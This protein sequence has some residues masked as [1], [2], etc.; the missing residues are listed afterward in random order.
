MGARR[1]G[2]RGLVSATWL[3]ICELLLTWYT[4]F[5]CTTWGRDNDE[6]VLRDTDTGLDQAFIG[7]GGG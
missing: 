5:I 4:G 7:V 2:Q 1:D 3:S 6:F